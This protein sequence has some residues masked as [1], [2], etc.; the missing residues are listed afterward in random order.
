MKTVY[1]IL[2]KAPSGER[3]ECEILK[4][5]YSPHTFFEMGLVRALY[6]EP[7]NGQNCAIVPMTGNLFSVQ[8]E[9]KI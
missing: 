7:F 9:D 6:G 5:G 1:C 2:V 4:K 3:V 8:R